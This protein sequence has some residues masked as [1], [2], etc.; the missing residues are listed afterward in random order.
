MQRSKNRKPILPCMAPTGVWVKCGTACPSASRFVRIIMANKM[1][2]KRVGLLG[3]CLI[4]ES[5]LRVPK[6]RY[7]CRNTQRNMSAPDA[8]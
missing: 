4:F 1:Q 3:S 2:R 8:Q 6:C 7:R 5:Q